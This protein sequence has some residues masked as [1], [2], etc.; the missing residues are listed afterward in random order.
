M[1]QTQRRKDLQ[2]DRN[3][4][5]DLLNLVVRRGSRIQSRDDNARGIRCWLPSWCLWVDWLQFWGHL[6]EDADE[7]A[8]QEM[9]GARRDAS[10]R[11]STTHVT[12]NVVHKP[13]VAP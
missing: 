3:E 2:L 13:R 7:G 8:R 4:L 10:G 5:F 6:R 11:Q 1:N 9:K 12:I